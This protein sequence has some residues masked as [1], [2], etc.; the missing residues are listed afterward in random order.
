M[1]QHGTIYVGNGHAATVE[2]DR[3]TD[4]FVAIIIVSLFVHIGTHTIGAGD[5]AGIAVD[6]AVR[7]SDAYA[8]TAVALASISVAD[9]IQ[10]T[11]SVVPAAA[12]TA[13]PRP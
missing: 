5:A 10:A 13:A 9:T 11:P 2:C 6:I 4:I 1:R 3:I 12:T 7:P 8:G